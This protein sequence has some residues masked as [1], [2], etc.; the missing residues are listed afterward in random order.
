MLAFLR[1]VLR[2]LVTATVV[3]SLH[4]LVTLTTK[5][6]L[7]TKTSVLTRATRRRLLYSETSDL[8]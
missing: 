7:S 3:P 2:L 6:I 4:N 5:A 8:I 1:N